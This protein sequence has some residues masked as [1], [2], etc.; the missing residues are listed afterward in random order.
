MISNTS[1]PHE[2]TNH[3]RSLRIDGVMMAY[4]QSLGSLGN[5]GE[6][7]G[8]RLASMLADCMHWCDLHKVDFATAMRLST[9]HHMAERTQ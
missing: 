3:E 5:E 4:Q 2:P 9:L 7:Q 1:I 6:S 8:D